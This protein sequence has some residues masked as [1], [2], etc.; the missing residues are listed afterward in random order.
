ML[1]LLQKI[2]NHKRLIQRIK[3]S[4]NNPKLLLETAQQLLQGSYCKQDLPLAN[5]LYTEAKKLSSDISNPALEVLSGDIQ[6]INALSEIIAQDR[7]VRSIFS[8]FSS[9]RLEELSKR[10]YANAL[11]ATFSAIHA[12]PAPDAIKEKARKCLDLSVNLCFATAILK[13]GNL[14]YTNNPNA[15][16]SLYGIATRLHHPLALYKYAEGLENPVQRKKTMEK[17]YHIA[18][19]DKNWVLV[20][21]IYEHLPNRPQ[22]MKHYYK[23]ASSVSS[24]TTILRKAANLYA[25]N[26]KKN[27]PNLRIAS[28]F[29]NRAQ[30]IERQRLNMSSKETESKSLTPNNT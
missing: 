5:E 22:K 15:A 11:F 27:K 6:D 25:E 4:P 16:K 21:K 18:L 24:E 14:I 7:S 26:S 2:E 17:A 3:E 10:Q 28:M 13:K 9:K 23:M 1:T 8:R 30:K 19:K 29:N 20:T 12:R